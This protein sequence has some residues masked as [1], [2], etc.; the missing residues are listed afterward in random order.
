MPR[1]PTQADAAA[2]LAA[3][4]A[5]G[6]APAIAR[7]SA[8]AELAPRVSPANIGAARAGLAD[9]DPMVR[10]GALDMLE[11]LPAGQIWPLVSPLLADPVRGVRIRAA[12]LL[13]AVP[14]AS[15]PPADRERFDAA[16]EEFVAAQRFNADRPEARTTLGNFLAQRGRPTEAETEYK[17]ALRL[18]PQYRRPRQSIWPTSTGSSAATTTAKRVLRAA[19]RPRRATPARAP[20]ARPR[21]DQAQAAGR[22]A[23]RISHSAAELEPDSARYHYVYAVALHSAGQRDEAMTVLKQAAAEPSRRSRYP[24]GADLI[25]PPRRRRPGRA[26]ICRATRSHHAGGPG[27]GRAHPATSAG[28]QVSSAM[29]ALRPRSRRSRNIGQ[30]L[31]PHPKRSKPF[32]QRLTHCEQL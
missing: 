30:N 12:S 2:L 1:A 25:Q 13:A 6:N 10:I 16:A 17:A 27:F 15:Q 20:R 32:C 24:V 23:R 7:A 3:V 31:R 14:A 4:A 22:R 26:R 28:N 18:S 21:P 29:T 9:P 19:S 11:N 8:L 5:D